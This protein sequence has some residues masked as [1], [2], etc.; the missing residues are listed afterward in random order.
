MNRITASSM[1]KSD[2]MREALIWLVATAFFLLMLLLF[3]PRVRAACETIERNDSITYRGC[4]IIIE[5]GNLHV[6]NA[7]ARHEDWEKN[8]GTGNIILGHDHAGQGKGSHNFI[9]GLGIRR[10]GAIYSLLSGEDIDSSGRGNASVG[11]AGHW[12]HGNYNTITGGADHNTFVNAEYAH[13]GGGWLH[14][15]HD[16]QFNKLC[17]GYQNNTRNSQGGWIGDCNHCQ[18]EGSLASIMGGLAHRIGPGSAWTTIAGGIAGNA[19]GRFETLFPLCT[20]EGLCFDFPVEDF[21]P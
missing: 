13:I 3:A 14:S 10:H 20:E 17:G 7:F 4:D 1:E 5:G 8:D 11:G 15:I 9:H 12:A 6:R 16:G 19:A 2:P 21:D 18:A